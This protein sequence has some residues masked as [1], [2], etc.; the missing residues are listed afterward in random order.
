MGFDWEL[1][2]GN[3]NLKSFSIFLLLSLNMAEVI[4]INNLTI[5]I[6]WWPYFFIAVKYFMIFLTVL[7][8]LSIVLI[9]IRTQS[10]LKV[11]L[12]AIMEKA[13][14]TNKMSRIKWLKKW[15]SIISKAESD[16]SRDYKDAVI[17][18]EA[19]LDDILKIAN[20]SGEN[21]ESRLKKIPDNQ[22]EFKEDIIWAHK[23]K[24]RIVLEENFEVDREEARRAVYIFQR[25]LKKMGVI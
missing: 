20:F 15:E 18:A 21:I 16:D 14:K 19:F 6:W 7:L 5:N 8:A 23:L 22:L 13:L 1:E 3:W 10:F 4:E 24:E 11:D 17:S 9:F 25:T 12:G 2:L